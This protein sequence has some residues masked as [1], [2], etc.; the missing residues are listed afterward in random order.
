MGRRIDFQAARESLHLSLKAQIMQT[1]GYL[2]IFLG[3][4]VRVRVVLL[5]FPLLA[6]NFSHH[7]QAIDVPMLEVAN[8]Q[9]GGR[10]EYAAALE[11]CQ[12]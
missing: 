7:G 2:G 4:F 12:G 10:V 6:S 5:A 11:A 3:F 9:V 8:L 1:G